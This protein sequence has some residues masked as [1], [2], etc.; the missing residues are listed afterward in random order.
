MSSYS[1]IGTGAVGGYYGGLLAKSG[2]EAHFLVSSRFFGIGL[3]A[4]IFFGA[5]QHSIADCPGCGAGL[6]IPPAEILGFDLVSTSM[7]VVGADI[8]NHDIEFGPIYTAGFWGGCIGFLAGSLMAYPFTN[9]G[10]GAFGIGGVL[11]G[12]PVGVAA[13]NVFRFNREIAEDN[14]AAFRH[15]E[16]PI[17]AVALSSGIK[18]IRLLYRF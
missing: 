2:R 11:V 1:I 13:G 18:E 4:C 6:L 12:I 3:A 5:V 16:N 8:F 15:L 10:F 7:L 9:D 14:S 17:V